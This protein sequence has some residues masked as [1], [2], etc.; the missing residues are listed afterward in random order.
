M[1]AEKQKARF[2][3]TAKV[4]EKIHEKLFSLANELI[5]GY[6]ILLINTKIGK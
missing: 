2:A 1:I 4:L 5:F 6:I 3:C